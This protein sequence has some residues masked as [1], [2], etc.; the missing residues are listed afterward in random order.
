MQIGKNETTI[1]HLVLPSN[2]TL[3]EMRKH[4]NKEFNLGIQDY[5]LFFANYDVKL[6]PESEED[7]AISQIEEA[8]EREK[9]DIMI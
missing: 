2:Y 8:R 9:V 5:E 1:K 7:Y 4:I 3:L 6:S